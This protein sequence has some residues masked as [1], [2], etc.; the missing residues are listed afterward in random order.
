MKKILVILISMLFSVLVQAKETE[1]KIDENEFNQ[2]IVTLKINNEDIE[3]KLDIGSVSALSLSLDIIN[4]IPNKVEKKDKLKSTDALGNVHYTRQFVLHDLNID[5]LFYKKLDVDELEP[6]GFV[7]DIESGEK[8]ANSPKGLNSKQMAIVGLGL[9]A[10]QIVT[11]DLR[12]NRLIVSDDFTTQLDNDWIPIPFSTTERGHLLLSLTD[13]LKNYILGLDTAAGS[14]MIMSQRLSK[15]AKL[16]RQEDIPYPIT[17]LSFVD[18][19]NDN[20]YFL[21]LDG[22]TDQ[23]PVDGLLGYD[24]FYN[25]IIKIDYEHKKIWVKLQ[26][27]DEIN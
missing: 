10:D 17:E 1:W 18:I 13:N 9:F 16:M 19:P 5:D 11:I 26:P 15:G 24:F 20:D 21:V 23:M 27:R 6:W 14:N 7:L 4:K 8:I 25:H 3:C 12:D 2:L 22:L